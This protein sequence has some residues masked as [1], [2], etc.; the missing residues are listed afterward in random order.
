[1][2]LE[3]RI[4]AASARVRLMRASDREAITL[5]SAVDCSHDPNIVQQ[6]FKNDA[7]VNTI[8]RRFGL[9]QVSRPRLDGVYGDFTGIHDYQSALARIEQVRESFMSLDPEIRAEF[10]NDPGK[11]AAFAQNAESEDDLRE[12]LGLP[13]RAAPAAPAAPQPPAAPA[14]PA[15]AAPS[16]PQG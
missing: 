6:S 7:D 8:V 14:A 15:P 16:P 9:G 3:D 4:A 13:A 1:M 2:K 11:F 12:A 10:D 5:R